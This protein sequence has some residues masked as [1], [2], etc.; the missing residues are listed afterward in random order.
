MALVSTLS[1]ENMNINTKTALASIALCISFGA[2]AAQPQS[3][4]AEKLERALDRSGD[5]VTITELPNGTIKIE[6]HDTFQHA[7]LARINERGEVETLCAEHAHRAIDFLAGQNS[8]T[9]ITVGDS[10]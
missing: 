2:F 10:Q 7:A 3:D 4:A 6:L 8:A 1:S 9:P 5:S